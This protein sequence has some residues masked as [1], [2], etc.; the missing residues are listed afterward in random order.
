MPK[1]AIKFMIISALAFALLNVFVK[2][3]NR[4]SV[5]EIV[6]FRSIGTL[7]FT[8][9]LLIKNKIS[10]F[11][12]KKVLLL[13]RGLIGFTAMTF[14]YLSLKHL[15]S[16]SVV[17]IRYTS[18]IFAALFSLALL[19]EKIK[20]VQWLFFIIAFSG[21]VIFKG[22]DNEI[23]TVGLMYAL[24]SSILLG[25][26][27]IIIRK[28]GNSDHPLVIVNYYMIIST[29]IGGL[30][31][32]KNWVTPQGIEWLLLLSLGVFGYYGQLYMT[33][34]FQVGEIN[35]VAPLKYTEVIFT[36][37]IGM[38]WLDETYSL[39]SL[40]AVL[41]IIVGLTLNVLAVNNLFSKSN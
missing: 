18:P 14:F 2:S 31:A 11:G 4:F 38:I 36:I 6:F 3:L 27:F 25:L 28:I 29:T 8:F 12:N 19:N 26:V 5:Y 23:N 40:I 17:S 32:Y 20:P 24:V 7:F 39:W 35:Q 13:L 34:A 10:I 15:S 22:F 16:G 33:K 30:L 41:L 37:L 21:V 1:K 9:S